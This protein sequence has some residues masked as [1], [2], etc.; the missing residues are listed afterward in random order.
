M[1]HLPIEFW[2]DFNATVPG[3]KLGELLDGNP[4]SI[5]RTWSDGRFD[6]MFDFPLA[7]AITDVFCRGQSPAK[8]AAVI[9]NDR[10]YPDPS[11]LVT[12]VDNHDL[13][14]IMSACGGDLAKV[15]Q[16]LSFMFA[17][18]GV[19]SIIWGTEEGF[20]GDR[21][22]ANRAQMKFEPH[23][24][25]DFIS[26]WMKRRAET[27]AL[28]DGA[29]LP[30]EVDS[31][32][33]VIARIA[34]DGTTV[35]VRV[36]NGQVSVVPAPDSSLSLSAQ[37]RTGAKKKTRVFPGPGFLTGSGPEFGD[38]DR[39]KALPLPVTVELPVYGAFEFKRIVNGEYEAGA[40]HVLFVAP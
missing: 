14:R 19:P 8:L 17:M 23:P 13:P 11:Q 39:E 26:A 36:E 28:S 37:W 40:N 30:L 38:W 15:E 6:A 27:P 16:A 3:W 9:S 7:F 4:G 18:R 31:R 21:E 22:P 2:D 32:H 12:L 33:V 25:K 24:L 35:H 10:R 34:P 5:A 20:A 1:K 29:A